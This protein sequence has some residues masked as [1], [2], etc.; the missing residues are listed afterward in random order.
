M[1][2]VN[3][4]FD[5]SDIS[6]DMLKY[7][8]EVEVTCGAPLVRD[9]VKGGQLPSVDVPDDQGRLKAN[10]AVATDT[11]CRKQRSGAKQ[12]KWRKEHPHKQ[13]GWKPT[14]TC[15]ADI[16]PCTVLDP[17]S[18]SGTTV[19]VALESGRNGVGFDLNE[20]YQVIARERIA[21]VTPPMFA[22]GYDSVLLVTSDT[23]SDV[24]ESLFVPDDY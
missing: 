11:A 13:K 1:G 21:G 10:G 7:F 2:Y 24:Q 12:A 15:D 16:V 4:L 23:D 3:S 17:F 8:I 14:C 9:V 18:G 5:V 20:E 22:A 19:T 6:S